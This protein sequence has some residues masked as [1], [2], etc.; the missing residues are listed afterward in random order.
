[1]CQSLIRF[2]IATKESLRSSELTLFNNLKVM[3]VYL[4]CIGFLVAVASWLY[5]QRHINDPY[6]LFHLS[7]NKLP[8][9]DPNS[10]PETEWLNVGYWKVFSDRISIS[11]FFHHATISE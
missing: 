2:W 8:S 3:T 9:E 10:P 4:T 7:L 5:M 11:L 1:V 6:G